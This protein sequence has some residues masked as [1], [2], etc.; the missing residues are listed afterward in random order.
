MRLVTLAL[1]LSSLVAFAQEEQDAG[2]PE[3]VVPAVPAPLPVAPPVAA[4]AAPSV[5]PPTSSPQGASIL[6]TILE[7][8][9]PYATLKP[10]VI[11]SGAAVES[12]SQPNASAVTAAGNPVLATLPTESR[13]TFQV[14]QSRTGAWFNEKGVV[15]GHLEVDFID[16]SKASPTVAS[17]PRLRIA[18]IDWAPTKSF[19]LSAGQDWDLHAPINPH[20]SNLVGARFLS[21]NVG[22]MR[23]Q[24]KAIGRL[25]DLELAG[26]VGLT[27]ANTGAKD[28]AVELSPIPT[29]AVRASY[30][31]GKG[32]IGLSG[33]ATSLRLSPGAATERHAFAGGG[34]VFADVTFGHTNLRGEL[35]LGQNMANLGLLTLGLGGPK[36]VA[37]W[38][39]FLSVRHGI[40]DMHFIYAT[41]GF[42]HALNR[43]AVRPSYSYATLP[44]DGLPAMSSAA[45]AGTGPGILHNM[46]ATLGYELRLNKNLGFLLEGFVMQ[47]EH[48]LIDFDAGRTARVRNAFGGEL[49]ALVSF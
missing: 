17:L 11:V 10:T 38:G 47:T 1:V 48:Q 8:F 3:A 32:R 2:L 26:A 25:G 21:G 36:D 42:G 24:V 40:T 4:I 28:A 20:G 34:T 31:V 6:D 16:F 15:R 18:N 12:Y 13:L 33:I 37:E 35:S 46:G 30:L 9:H 49:A 23:Q 44:T 7:A 19:T 27:A 45:I 22:F 29:F 14:A 5:L 43:D 41:V 39:G